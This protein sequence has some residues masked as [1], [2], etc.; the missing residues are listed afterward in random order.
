MIAEQTYYSHALG[1]TSALGSAFCWALAAILFRKVG[2][3]MSAVG[4]NLSK[5]I[6]AFACLGFLMLV[7]EIVTVDA[8]SMVLLALSGI[9]G[10]CLG[11]TLYFSTL[12]RLGPRVTLL[13]GSLIPIIAGLIAVVFLG[14]RINVFSTIGI[15]LTIIGIVLVLWEQAPADSSLTKWKVGLFFGLLFVFSEAIG[16]IFTKMGVQEI[17]SMQATFIRQTAAIMGLSFWGLAAGSLLNWLEPLKEKKIRLRIYVASLIGAF[18]GTWLS[19]FA[20]KHTYAS[21][22]A[23]L[24]STSPLFVLPLLMLITHEKISKRA[25]IGATITVIGI[26]EYFLTLHLLR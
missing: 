14:E 5:G 1:A 6:I 25:F 16:I 23:A 24:N 10:I 8:Q 21:V 2:G 9:I 11:D 3:Q 20:L 18:L 22:A 26:A 13:V 19:V 7:T 15:G 12:M 17:P 4:I